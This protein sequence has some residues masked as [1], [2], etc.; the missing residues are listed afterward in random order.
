[1]RVPQVHELRK[2][3]LAD[4]KGFA[5]PRT[6]RDAASKLAAELIGLADKVAK[7]GKNGNLTVGKVQVKDGRLEIRVYLADLSDE[8]LAKLKALGF[9]ELGQAKS[10]KLVIGTIDV[11]QLEALSK[12]DAVQ[13]IEPSL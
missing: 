11:K 12:L 6:P 7:E 8:V 1:M 3:E 13:R 4:P 5:G 9:Q 2:A 10:V